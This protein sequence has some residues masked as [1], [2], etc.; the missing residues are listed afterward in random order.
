MATRPS[1]VSS[2]AATAQPAAGGSSLRAAAADFVEAGPAQ[3]AAGGQEGEGLQQVGLAGAVFADQHDGLHPAIEAQL[4][5]VAEV[6]QAKLAHGEECRR[7]ARY[8]VGRV[9][10]GADGLRRHTRIG[11]ST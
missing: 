10:E 8:G 4:T 2:V 7:S 3:A 1:G 11:M 6:G 9:G 5:V